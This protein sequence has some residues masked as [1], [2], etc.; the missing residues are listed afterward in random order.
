M[1]VEVSSRRFAIPLECPCCGATTESETTIPVTRT[2]GKRVADERGLD[3]PYCARCL[4]HATAWETAGVG[5][6]GVMLIGIVAAIALAVLVRVWIGLAAFA[7]VIPLA[8]LLRQSRRSAARSAC[9]PSCAS[10]GKALAYFGWSGNERTF[11]FESPT[12][13][14][15]FGE[16]NQRHL[17][18]V[19]PQLT[20]IMDGLRI[21]RL[22]VPTPAAANLVVPPPA[23]LSEWIARIES[24]VGPVARRSALQRGLDA[25][26]DPASRQK[27][28][29]AACQIE[30]APILAQADATI[31]PAARKQLLLQAIAEIS[32]DNILE[33]LQTA[34]LREL[35]ARLAR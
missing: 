16:Q 13:A 23:S 22:T 14:A 7:L 4:A 18:N 3:F 1:I 27:L 33:E 32:G 12:Y 19:S 9:G 6:A 8:A 10:P 26:S 20:K 5:S 21:A 24:Q 35:E 2:P 28:I 11:S 30:L 15:R 29:A 31:N 17:V 25:T 34:E